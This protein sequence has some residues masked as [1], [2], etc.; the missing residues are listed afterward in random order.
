[1]RQRNSFVLGVVLAAAGVIGLATGCG[2]AARTADDAGVSTSTAVNP[3]ALRF[4]EYSYTP[5]QTPEALAAAD[6]IKVT[7]VGT[8]EGFREGVTYLTEP[9]DTPYPRVYMVVRV[10]RAFKGAADPGVLADGR[11]FVEFDRGPIN[12]RDGRTPL[13]S[14]D[15]FER[16]VPRGT[17]VALFLTDAPTI[18]DRVVDPQLAPRVRTL[19]PH[20]QGL[21]FEDRS[22][23]RLVPGL[24][25]PEE[26]P[27]PWR[28]LSS[29]D[30]LTARMAGVRK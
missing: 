9:G 11:L 6:Y 3:Q 17:R 21:V 8:V 26:L 19:V 4:K 25:V 15:V 30:E 18:S 10:D 24:I 13:N 7:A 22:R 20:P 5:Q 16:E 2:G 12:A 29:L 1:M 28:A 14:M 27:R 23:G